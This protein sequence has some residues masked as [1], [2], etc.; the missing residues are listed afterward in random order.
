[1]ERGDGEVLFKGYGVS[2]QENKKVLKMDGNNVN[3]LNTTELYT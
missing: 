2:V 1:M 3:I